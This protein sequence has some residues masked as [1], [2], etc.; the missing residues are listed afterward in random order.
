MPAFL[1]LIV[2]VVSFSLMELIM[3]ISMIQC[4][5][6]HLQLTT[7]LVIGR[8]L[9]YLKSQLPNHNYFTKLI[10]LINPAN[11]QTRFCDYP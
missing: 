8:F 9:N 4:F 10:N 5:I 6:Q 1:H 11:L 7:N 2:G 3:M